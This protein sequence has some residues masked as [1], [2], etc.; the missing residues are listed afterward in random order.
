MNVTQ[1]QHTNRQYE[2]ELRGLR[3]GLIKMGGLVESQITE[4]VE[5][6]V[7]RDSVHARTVIERDAEV[8]RMDIETDGRCI[9]LLALHQPAASDLRFITTG[10]KIT[11][12][13]ERI[14]D[15]A[16]NICERALE[17]NEEPQLKPYIDIP[18]MASIAQTMVKDSLDAFM[19]NDTTLA[20]QVIA[21]DDEVDLLNYQIYRELL[22]FMA[23]DPH[24]IGVA[25]RVLFVSKYLERIAD[26][27]TN[28]AEMVVYMVEGKNIKHMD[29]KHE[30][31]S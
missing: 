29:P 18:R 27:A 14:G 23:E 16:V 30:Q 12:D 6:L 3:A 9:N 31:P 11:T 26:H 15:N 7:E 25:T 10:L 19:R 24:T 2:E 21:R 20:E 1:P 8:N 17:L 4:A 5:A 22:S 28:I 13:L